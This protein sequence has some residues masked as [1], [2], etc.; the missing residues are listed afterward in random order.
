MRRL[1]KVFLIVLCLSLIGGVALAHPQSSSS[2]TYVS[3][4]SGCCRIRGYSSVTVGA[5]EAVH[6][7]YSVTARAETQ[8][9]YN[10]VCDS[11]SCWATFTLKY[12]STVAMTLTSGGALGQTLAVATWTGNYTDRAVS[13]TVSGDHRATIFNHG[14]L[15]Y[16]AYMT[17]WTSTGS[18]P[19][20]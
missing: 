12:G 3:C 15:G 9:L 10:T 7:H 18:V 6:G 8:I 4:S 20:P 13:W 11:V 1:L 2:T 16:N 19:A 5:W 17:C 14:K